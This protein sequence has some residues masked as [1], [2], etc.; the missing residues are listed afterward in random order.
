MKNATA[1][2]AVVRVSVLPTPAGRKQRTAATAAADAQG[3][4]FRP[5]QQDDADQREGMIRWMTSRTVCMGWAFGG[6]CELRA[7]LSGDMGAWQSPVKNEAATLEVSLDN[8]DEI[9]CLEA[10]S[11]DQCAV[12][13]GYRANAWALR[14][15][16]RSAIENTDL[17]ARPRR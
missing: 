11:A 6:I 7:C 9:D 4:A 16:D 8:S 13:V 14:G 1:R 5:L 12:H 17:R 10:C 15:L 2:M 3:P